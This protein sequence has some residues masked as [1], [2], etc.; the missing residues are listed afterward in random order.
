[1]G[2]TAIKSISNRHQTETFYVKNLEHPVVTQTILI[3][4]MHWT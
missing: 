3:I 2:V 4:L 1:M